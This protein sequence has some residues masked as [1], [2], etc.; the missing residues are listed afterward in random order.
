MLRS[1]LCSGGSCCLSLIIPCFFG[2]KVTSNRSLR[3]VLVIEAGSTLNATRPLPI[4]LRAFLWLLSIL[5][6][7]H[8]LSHRI[9]SEILVEPFVV[10]LDHRGVDA[11]AEALDF[12]QSE[13]TVSASLVIFNAIEIFDCLNDL[14]GL[15][16]KT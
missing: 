13:E 1:F 7:L 15:Y 14:S 5:P 6:V 9:V 11:G 12:L 8:Q 4:N 2:S 10:D 3:V 16:N